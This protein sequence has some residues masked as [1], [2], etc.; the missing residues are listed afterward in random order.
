MGNSGDLRI[1]LRNAFL[2]IDHQYHDLRTFHG[3]DGTD[4]HVTLQFFLDLVLPAKTGSINEDIFFAVI[5][6]LSIYRISGGTRDI[7]NDQ[8]VLTKQFVDQGRLC[9]HWVSND[10][11]TGAVILFFL[12]LLLIKI[13]RDSLQHVT[14]SQRFTAE[15][16]WG[17]PIPR[18]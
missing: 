1:L 16:G 15:I 6:D 11:H 9:R 10:S 7:R 14:D 2:C 8:T 17:S 12:R 18:L 3:T 4:D 5:S 13:F